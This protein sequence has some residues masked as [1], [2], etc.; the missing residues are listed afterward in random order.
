VHNAIA[1]DV[2]VFAVLSNSTV[3]YLGELGH[4]P[5]VHTYGHL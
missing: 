4:M 1:L 3:C 5:F 2:L